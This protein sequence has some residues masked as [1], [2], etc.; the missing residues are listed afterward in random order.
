MQEG[1]GGDQADSRDGM[2]YDT[3]NFMGQ[4]K[5]YNE[6]IRNPLVRYQIRK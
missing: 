6:K 2:G 3:L 1:H 4:Y 5:D